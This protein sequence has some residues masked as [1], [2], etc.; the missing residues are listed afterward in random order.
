MGEFSCWLYSLAIFVLLIY[1]SQ[2]INEHVYTKTYKV[3]CSQTQV[4][5]ECFQTKRQVCICAHQTHINWGLLSRTEHGR[6]K[7]EHFISLPCIRGQ[8]ATK[9]WPQTHTDE[10]MNPVCPAIGYITSTK[11]QSDVKSVPH[12]AGNNSLFLFPTTSSSDWHNTW[13]YL[14]MTSDSG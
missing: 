4:I 6:H 2:H 13:S 5:I 12:H 11:Q 9:M 14:R 7:G 10:Q 3:I 8:W 1:L